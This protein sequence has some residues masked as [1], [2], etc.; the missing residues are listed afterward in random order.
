MPEAIRLI[1]INELKSLVDLEVRSILPA[2]ARIVSNGIVDKP[3]IAIAN[4]NVVVGNLDVFFA[5]DLLGV[6]KV[7]VFEVS[8]K[9]VFIEPRD[10][11]NYVFR[12]IN[13]SRMLLHMNF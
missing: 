7:P 2:Y 8:S 13:E 4:R 6:S 3:V 9:D 10:A 11:I 12:A 1:D 5:L